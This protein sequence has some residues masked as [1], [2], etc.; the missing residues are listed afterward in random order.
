MLEKLYEAIMKRIMSKTQIRFVDLDYGQYE[1]DTRPA[2]SFP[3]VLIDFDSLVYSDLGDNVQE[4]TGQIILR[5]GVAEYSPSSSSTP[6][7]WRKKGLEHFRQEAELH[8]A[9]HGWDPGIDDDQGST[10]V[11]SRRSSITEKRQD[12]LRIREIRYEFRYE[13]YTTADPS[14]TQTVSFETKIEVNH[15]Q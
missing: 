13:D 6:E 10:S 14:E 4:C 9:L 15:D 2:T 3:A 7:L 8:K 11:L 1:F 5:M 12:N